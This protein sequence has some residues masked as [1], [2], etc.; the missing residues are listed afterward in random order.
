MDLPIKFPSETEVILADVARSRAL[1][2]SDQVRALVGLLRAGDRIRQASPKAAWA[3][4]YVE[5]Q[6]ILAQRRIREFLA[7]HGY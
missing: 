4:Q 3:A 5:E 2:P 1:T 6:E 7:R